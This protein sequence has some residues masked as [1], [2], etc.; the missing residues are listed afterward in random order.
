MKG[1]PKSQTGLRFAILS[2]VDGPLVEEG[3]V[4]TSTTERPLS[5]ERLDRCEM[6]VSQILEEV[7]FL[8]NDVSEEEEVRR[9][10]KLSS[11]TDK[12][13]RLAC[14]LSL[15][16]RQVEYQF[17]NDL[18]NATFVVKDRCFLS[19]RT[20]WLVNDDEV[21]TDNGKLVVGM[22]LDLIISP[23]VKRYREL[24]AG[25]DDEAMIISR[26]ISWISNDKGSLPAKR[27]A[28]KDASDVNDLDRPKHEREAADGSRNE[29]S[30]WYG[31][32]EVFAQSESPVM[33]MTEE[34]GEDKT[35]S[36]LQAT[37]AHS[38]GNTIQGK[39]KKQ[40]KIADSVES[41]G[42]SKSTIASTQK[43]ASMTSRDRPPDSPIVSAGACLSESEPIEVA[44]TPSAK[45]A[46]NSTGTQ[47]QSGKETKFNS[48]E[49]YF[50][51]EGESPR[52]ILGASSAT[53]GMALP[54]SPP[55]TGERSRRNQA[56]HPSHCEALPGKKGAVSPEVKSNVA[57]PHAG[58][59]TIPSSQTL[60]MQGL[61]SS[62]GKEDRKK[63]PSQEPLPK[64]KRKRGRPSKKPGGNPT[65]KP[66]DIDAHHPNKRVVSS[67]QAGLAIR[68]RQHVHPDRRQKTDAPI[69]IG[70]SDDE[71][72]SRSS[73][74]SV[75]LKQPNQR[76]S[77]KIAA[78]V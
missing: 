70:S 4:E 56:N 52:P 62:P 45:S 65:K 10:I 11:F 59:D 7:R 29:D 68:R 1:V 5:Q 72:D 63:D 50:A 77:K 53:S 60:H 41:D 31:R 38:T 2:A 18:P 35:S 58:S 33:D 26:G 66:V 22:P 47:K 34:N 27:E 75:T 51:H 36:S 55:N 6:V 9:R 74:S 14:I 54:R 46:E 24:G 19:Y 78:S 37:P 44:S 32:K 16:N 48:M 49:E 73:G 43:P 12:A 13:T 8:L 39:D 25:N 3:K 23:L 20:L 76:G 67:S 15:Q 40:R 30:R 69:E 57:D 61:S 64:Q 42:F 17:L 21:V 28:P 71:G